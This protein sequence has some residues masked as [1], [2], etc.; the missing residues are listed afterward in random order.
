MR[1]R[2][3]FRSPS[4]LAL[5]L[6]FGVV[7]LS[8]SPGHARIPTEL[9]LPE[10]STALKLEGRLTPRTYVELTVVAPAR[11]QAVWVEQG[12]RVEEGTVLARLDGY[13]H[14]RAELAAARLE[15]V[16]ARQSMED[17][18]RTAAVQLAEAEIAW[19]RAEKERDFAADRLASLEKSRE[20]WR[21]EQARVNSLLAEKRLEQLREDLQKARQKFNKQKDMMWYF[22]DRRQYRLLITGLE[23]QVALAERRY[24]DARDKYEELLEPVDEIDLEIARADL[25]MAEARLRQAE[26]ERAKLLGGPRPEDVEAARA[27]L[28]VALTRLASAEAALRATEVTS[29]IT[30]VVVKL[31]AKA[32][33][34]AIPGRTLAVVADLSDWMVEVDELSEYAAAHVLP[35]QSVSVMLVPYP[36]QEL[37]G[38]IE[39]IS[40]YSREDEG[41]VFFRARIRL[42]EPTVGLRWGMTARL[43]ISSH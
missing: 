5:I 8:S 4:S 24:W 30:G 38:V 17:L 23:K 29:P 34:W 13:D 6:V 39:S 10:A 9:S 21:I 40:L 22:V 14:A 37:S 20:A 26:R 42:T 19:R 2:W 15:L 16:L 28:K 11:L 36:E 7:I 1:P 33:E 3:P 41:Q 32:G 35:E 43:S 12:D 18:Y 27:R 25:T 31:N